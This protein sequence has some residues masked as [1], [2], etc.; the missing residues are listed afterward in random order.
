MSTE[1]PASDELITSVLQRRIQRLGSELEKMRAELAATRNRAGSFV[2]RADAT[3]IENSHL[4]TWRP[5][6][7]E[8]NSVSEIGDEIEAR[9]VT[10]TMEAWVFTAVS[11][12]IVFGAFYLPRWPGRA[13]IFV[14][15]VGVMLMGP[16]VFGND[17]YQGYGAGVVLGGLLTEHLRLDDVAV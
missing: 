16:S 1:V 13:V 2:A 10:L 7:R 15:L 6:N 11:L 5:S 4:K 3:R 17:W 12:G 8:G 9:G 14:V